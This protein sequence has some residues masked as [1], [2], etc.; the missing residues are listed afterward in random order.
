M[1]EFSGEV[2]CSY[3]PDVMTGLRCNQCGKPICAKDALRTPVGLRCPECA[4]VRSMPSIRTSG[5][6][7]LKAIG[8]GILVAL[9]VA[10]LWRFMPNWGF[11]LSL[12]MGFGVVETMSAMSRNKRGRDLQLAAILIITVGFALSRVF[13]AQR[14][15]IDLGQ[16]NE[17]TPPIAR[18]LQL[19]AVPDL[20][21][22]GLA[23]VI[24][25]IRFR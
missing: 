24:A 15:G 13:L 7:L 4:G 2:P 5:D 25:W 17:L 20:I 6:V 16:I 14:Y 23:Y 11:Y 3:H 9:A 12:A 10:V 18:A 22:M 19:Q 1:H 8:G 21:Y